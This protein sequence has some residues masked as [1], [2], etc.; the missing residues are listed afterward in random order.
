MKDKIVAF[1]SNTL[2]ELIASIGFL[3][4][5]FVNAI[6]ANA[7]SYSDL[8]EWAKICVVISMTIFGQLF[9]RGLV[10]PAGYALFKFLKIVK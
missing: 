9:I 10:I 2:F 8:A 1:L 3:G 5:T 4:L 7:S 6:P